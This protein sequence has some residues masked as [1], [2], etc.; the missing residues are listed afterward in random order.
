MKAKSKKKGLLK[1]MKARK[2]YAALLMGFLTV[3]LLEGALYHYASG[4]FFLRYQTESEH[5][6]PTLRGVNRNLEHYPVVLLN[7]VAPSFAFFGYIF[8]FVLAAGA[9]IMYKRDA[10]AI[11]LLLWLIPVYFY[12][13]YGS[14]SLTSYLLI[15]RIWRFLCVLTIPSSLMVAYLLVN[16]RIPF[17]RYLIPLVIIFLGVSSVYYISQIHT[18]MDAGMVDFRETARFLKT[19]P[20]KD[21]YSDYDTLGKL[22]FL[23]GYERADYLKNIQ[24]VK[25]PAQIRDAYIVVNASRG[26]VE[27]KE[28]RDSMPSFFI[29]PPENWEVANVVTESDVGFWG[30]YNTTVYYA[31]L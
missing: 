26:V 10:R 13:Q 22:N 7:R 11:I 24:N 8:Y 25:D 5:Y 6:T 3:F 4:D 27:V 1:W 30:T 28:I 23:L 14:M 31:P 9:Y 16:M 19:Q 2:N 15:Q 18:F 12:L 20:P 17:R 29:S 21:I